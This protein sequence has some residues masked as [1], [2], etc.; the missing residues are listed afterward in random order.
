MIGTIFTNFEWFAAYYGVAFIMFCAGV[1]LYSA[2][3]PTHEFR[4][5]REGNVAGSIALAGV[6]IGM[7]IVLASVISHSNSLLVLVLWGGVSIVTQL[8]A[9]FVFRLVCPR[10]VCMIDEGK[11]GPAISLASINISSALIV[12]ACVTS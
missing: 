7:A 8:I 11:V 6:S 9:F 5:L 12:A 4:L 2:I 1:A 10:V 3:T